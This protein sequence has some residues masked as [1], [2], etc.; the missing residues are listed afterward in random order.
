MTL[1]ELRKKF[2]FKS[3][4]L[5]NLSIFRIQFN[6]AQECP[7]SLNTTYYLLSHTSVKCEKSDGTF[8]SPEQ[9][10]KIENPVSK[11]DIVFVVEE[12]RCAEG[13]IAD[14]LHDIAIRL[15]TELR[16]NSKWTFSKN[17]NHENVIVCLLLLFSHF[18]FLNV[19]EY[20]TTGY[21]KIHTPRVED[22]GKVYHR[23]IVNFFKCTYTFCV[24]F[25]LG[26]SPRE[27]ISYLEVPNELIYLE[28]TLPLC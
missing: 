6:W 24:I 4:A 12:K 1:H 20:C 5:K 11:A 13:D 17:I 28:F 25:R 8:I 19:L 23:E 3:S 7:Q 10:V 14:N 26:L 27:L 16:R 18:N 2:N 9:P 21:S 15:D 22:F